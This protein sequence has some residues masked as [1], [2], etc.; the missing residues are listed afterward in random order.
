MTTDILSLIAELR[1]INVRCLLVKGKGFMLRRKECVSKR[2]TDVFSCLEILFWSTIC[3]GVISFSSMSITK[4]D[5][6][7]QWNVLFQGC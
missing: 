2:Y 4:T 3:N 1:K 7:R 6:V 5:K